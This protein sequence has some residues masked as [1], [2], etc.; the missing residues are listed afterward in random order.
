[1]LSCAVF[2]S[3]TR[4]QE[5]A[6]EDPEM[7]IPQRVE[8]LI[9]ALESGEKID[10]LLADSPGVPRLD[11]PPYH[12]WN[13]ALHGVARNGRATVFP[14]AINLGATFDP[15]QIHR[16]GEAISTEARAKFNLARRQ[17]NRGQYA[18]LTFW[19]PTVNIFRDLRWGRGQETYGEDPLLTGSIGSALVR[20]MQGGHP[21]YLKAA[22]AAKHFA[23]HSG[24]EAGRSSFDAAVSPRDLTETYL[25]PFEMLVND[26]E[27]EGVMCAYN[28]INGIPA[29]ADE[30][31][32]RDMLRGSWNFNG[33]VVSDCGAIGNIYGYHEYA[34]SPQEAAAMA[35]KAGVNINCGGSWA[36]NLRAALEGGL[37]E[38]AD[39]DRALRESLPTLFRLGMF[40]PPGRDPWRE[41]GEGDLATDEHHELARETAARSMV[42]LKNEN[43][44]PLEAQLPSLAVM[45]PTAT[46]A[47]VLLG[48]YH[49]TSARLS[50]FLEGVTGAVGGGTKV[51]HYPGIDIEEGSVAESGWGISQAQTTGAIVACIGLSPRFEGEGREAVF[52]SEEPV[53]EL[54]PHQVE[55]V[56]ALREGYD[57]PL[58]VVVT[59]GSP[60]AIPEIHE[61]ADAVIWAGYP[62][63]AGG[64]ALADLLFGRA[65]PS[66]RLPVTVPYRTADL[67]P[68]DDYSMESR[69]YRFL[70]NEPLYPFGFGLSY[71]QFS[72]GEVIL[73]QAG[74]HV[75]DEGGRAIAS[76]DTVRVTVEVTNRGDRPGEE[77]VQIYLEDHESA[78]RIP[79][80]RL[81]DFRRVRLRPGQTATLDFEILPEQMTVVTPEGRRAVEPGRFTVHAGGASPLPRST[82]LG[83]PEFATAGFT[84][85]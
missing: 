7:D 23:V 67:P 8:A 29:C 63:E 51:I 82:A 39:L 57:G 1:M 22:A 35:L 74:Q 4:A 40:D 85:R 11:I 36:N 16:V 59:G 78:V 81:V 3:T 75:R 31:L 41:L 60:R 14:Q 56:R 42:L 58:V 80:Y 13:E 68:F 28:R 6:W 9:G 33:Y 19:S 61:M 43:V 50:T 18:G 65:N 30:A 46:S 53:V 54:P 24:P 55:W 25:P 84:V 17:G 66:G 45:G 62:G 70:E 34:D 71:T 20:G 32:L 79:R 15:V 38:E 5:R 83:A 27:V 44:L 76:G 10:L 2:V 52:G 64:E 73:R 69:T 26:A 77:V 21:E 49:G 12:W 48:N 47:E 37:A 72:Y